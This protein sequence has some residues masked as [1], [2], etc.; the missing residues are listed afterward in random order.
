M[1]EHYCQNFFRP[2][3]KNWGRIK[4]KFHSAFPTHRVDFEFEFLGEFKAIRE[5][6]L[7]HE[8]VAHGLCLMKKQNQNMQ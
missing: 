8:A 7:R 1:G 4:K 2:N 5:N 3:H 6:I